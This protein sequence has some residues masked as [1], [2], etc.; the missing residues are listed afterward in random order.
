V[1][2]LSLLV[3][4]FLEVFTKT[5]D[6]QISNN[7]HKSKGPPSK[8]NKVDQKNSENGQDLEVDMVTWAK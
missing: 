7:M 5:H 8:V 4:V 1:C 3:I 6:E 2:H